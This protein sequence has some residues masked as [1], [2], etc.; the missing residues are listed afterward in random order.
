MYKTNT[1]PDSVANNIPYNLITILEVYG[2]LTYCINK[3]RDSFN[4]AKEQYFLFREYLVELFKYDDDALLLRIEHLMT[5]CETDLRT[6]CIENGAKQAILLLPHLTPD[7]RDE[8]TEWSQS[9]MSSIEYK[10]KK[11]GVN[12]Q[13]FSSYLI[14]KA[15][16]LIENKKDVFDY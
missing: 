10:L 12:E 4:R 16:D 13:D 9:N 11:L 1:I 6:Y 3:D 8:L 15:D 2:M 14:D 7:Q 5:L